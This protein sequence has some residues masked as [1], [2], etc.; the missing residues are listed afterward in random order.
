MLQFRMLW[1]GETTI[2]ASILQMSARIVARPDADRLL[3]LARFEREVLDA[4]GLRARV[5]ETMC[6]PCGGAI[7]CRIGM[8]EGGRVHRSISDGVEVFNGNE[9]KGFNRCRVPIFNI[10]YYNQYLRHPVRRYNPAFSIH[11][12]DA[13]FIGSRYV[14]ETYKIAA[15]K[16][17][18]N[19][20]SRDGLQDNENR[21]Y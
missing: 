21:Q 15:A 17:I 2:S 14:R 20:N 3:R 4:H 11:D 8:C 18:P 19:F 13:H 9:G 1:V 16:A 7:L 12:P 5:A 6:L 10:R